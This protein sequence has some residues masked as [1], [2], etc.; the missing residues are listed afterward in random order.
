MSQCDIPSRGCA[1]SDNVAAAQKRMFRLAERDHKMSL[2]VIAAETGIPA[3]TLR[4]WIAGTT[5]MPLDG[6]VKISAIDGFPNEL[7]S[8]PFEHAEKSLGDAGE[9]ETDFH[10]MA[11]QCATYLLA[12]VR[13]QHRESP[14]CERIVHNEEPHLRLVAEG[15]AEKARKV[16]KG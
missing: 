4:G 11:V 1:I 3:G 7:L 16:T 5:M 10:D 12:H 2:K 6:F 13:A 15:V 8:L 14:G 9:G